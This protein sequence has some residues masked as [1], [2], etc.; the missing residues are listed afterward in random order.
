MRGV[1]LLVIEDSDFL[2][3]SLVVGLR[4]AGFGVDEAKDGASGLEFARL[5]HY[6]VVVLDLMLPLLDGLSVLRKLREGGSAVHVLILSAKDQ[7]EDRVRG[8]SFG[9]DDYLVK[10]FAF[11]ELVARLRSLQRRRH[12][13]KDPVARIGELEVDLAERRVTLDGRAL[14]LTPLEYALLELL[15]L[16]RGRLASREEILEQ[17]Y[18]SSRDV[19]SNVVEVL[20]RSLRAKI[21]P[22]GTREVLFNRRGFGYWLGETEP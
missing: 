18:D 12:D 9:A 16:K 7:V 19:A 11:E 3:E 2:R 14:R 1:K 10:P 20:V 13:R 8:L 4:K 21:Q 6:D 17:L 5:G 15:V 22:P